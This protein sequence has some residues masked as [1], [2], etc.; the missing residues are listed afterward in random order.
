MSSNHTHHVV[1]SMLHNLNNQITIVKA[2]TCPLQGTQI[3]G[4]QKCEDVQMNLPR[5]R[6]YGRCV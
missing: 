4:P 6:S 1:R 5:E 2:P 3:S